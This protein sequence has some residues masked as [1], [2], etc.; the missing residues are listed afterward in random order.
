MQLIE[1]ASC[2][3]KTVT[4]KFFQ[5]FIAFINLLISLVQLHDF[6]ASTE[7]GLHQKEFPLKQQAHCFQM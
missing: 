6:G 5:L 7:C 3:L 2:L 4:A 1:A